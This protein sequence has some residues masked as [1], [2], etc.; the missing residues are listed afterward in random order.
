MIKDAYSGDDKYIFVSYAHKDK[1]VVFPLIAKLQEKF[2]VWYDAG[3]KFGKEWDDEIATHLENCSLFIYAVS[4]NS[5]ESTNC[6]DEIAFARDTDIPFINIVIEDVVLPSNFKLRYGRYQMCFLNR[7][8][9]LDELLSDIVVSIK[10]MNLEA[11]FHLEEETKEEETLPEK[12]EDFDIKNNELIKYLGSDEEVI[13]PK[14]VRVIKENAFSNTSESNKIK[15]IITQKGLEIIE[16]GAFY[17]SN[18]EKIFL[19]ETVKIVSSNSFFSSCYFSCPNLDFISVSNHNDSLMSKDGIIYSKDEKT[20]LICPNGYQ[21]S[22][23]IIPNGVEVIASHAFYFNSNIENVIFPNTLARIEE[24][25]FAYSKKMIK[26][27]LPTSLQFLG[28]KAFYSSYSLETVRIPPSLKDFPF[29]AFHLCHK[30]WQLIITD[31]K[32][33]GLKFHY[34]SILDIQ[35]ETLLFHIPKASCN[36]EIVVPDG[37]TRIAPYAFAC[38][39]N[40]KNVVCPTSLIEISEGAFYN[41]SNLNFIKFNENLKIIG[42]KSV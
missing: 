32:A 23:L 30:L 1:G 39:H 36:S 33:H 12:L 10:E 11:I 29:S 40:I 8:S 21:N 17:L 25:A 26:V 35:G 14:C 37:V 15:K 18:L 5:L 42:K 3:I 27:E 13:I 28:E 4:K 31:Y 6:K 38:C 9:T 20:L 22:K 16:D 19:S 24:E 34:G 41:M 2:N 7:Y